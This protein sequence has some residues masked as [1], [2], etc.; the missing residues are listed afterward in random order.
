MSTE[1]QHPADVARAWGEAF[2]ARDLDAMMELFDPEAVWVSGEGEQVRGLD[3]IREVFAGFMA[4]E[5]A[6]FRP[7][8]PLV[9]QAG[10][11]AMLVADWRMRGT[12]ED[13]APFEVE[14]TTADVVRRGERGWR[15]VIDSP[16]GGARRGAEATT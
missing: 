2:A 4:I 7:S 6:V 15:Y 1:Q 9:H 14:G 11:V 12:G 5:D 10:D 16:F 8:E 3:A 13:G